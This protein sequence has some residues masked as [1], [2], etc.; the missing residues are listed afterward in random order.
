[1]KKSLKNSVWLMVVFSVLINTS[2]LTA[3]QKQPAAEKVHKKEYHEKMVNVGKLNLNFRWIKGND[4][5]IL[6]E[7][8]G[9]ADS[10]YWNPLVQEIAQ[11]TGATVVTYDR[12]GFGKSDL[13]GIPCDM[14]VETQWLMTGLKKLGF[15]K[16][17]VLV[18]H[19]YGGWMIK[20]I[21]HLFPEKIAGMVFVDPFSAELVDQLGVE[22]CDK[23]PMMGKLPFDTSQPEKLSKTEKALVR[24][25]K[26]GLKAKT[27]FMRHTN[28]PAGIPVILIT[29]GKSFLPKPEEFKAWGKSH[30]MMFAKMKKAKMKDIK[31]LVAEK[32]GHM[33][34]S[35]EPELVISCIAQVTGKAKKNLNL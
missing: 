25:V 27:D 9:G 13:T 34:P 29:A 12:A 19:S 23:H 17:L 5:T 7:A 8:G 11:K 33:I 20:A 1:M 4:I 6:M 15:D 10:T 24:M 30:Q 22:Y 28:V 26:N 18:G 31:V 16:N 3:Q 14:K 21:G 32:S 2:W 35:S